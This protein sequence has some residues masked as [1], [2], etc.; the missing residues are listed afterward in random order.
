MSYYYG[1]NN[2]LA[3]YVDS[4]GN[5]GFGTSNVSSNSLTTSGTIIAISGIINSNGIYAANVNDKASLPS[6]TW[7]DTSNYGIYRASNNIIGFSTSGNES[8]RIN[9]L[10]NIGI[11]TSN[12]QYIL[13][14]AGSIRT[15][16]QLNFNNQTRPN[17]LCLYGSCNISDTSNSYSFG[18]ISNSLLYNV[19]INALHQFNINGS[20]VMRVNSNSFIGI[21]NSNPQYNFDIIGNSRISSNLYVNRNIVLQQSNF[22]VNINP[23]SSST[24]CNYTITLPSNVPTNSNFMSFDSNGNGSFLQSPLTNV[25]SNNSSVFYSK[26]WTGNQVTSNGKFTV[27]PTSDGTSNGSA[28]FSNIFYASGTAI[29]NTSNFTSNCF[30]SPISIS[31][32]KRQVAFNCTRGTAVSSGLGGGSTNTTVASADGTAVYAMIVG[33]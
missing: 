31:T 14:V 33:L 5:I 27:F 21:N 3:M 13:D 24:A 1:N 7:A 20:E 6:F 32:D 11:G 9:Q 19:P 26:I 17:M 12:P 25:Y 8:M 30:V 22:S 28:L 16:S 2:N 18:M 4:Y 10:G 15:T 29:V 23:S